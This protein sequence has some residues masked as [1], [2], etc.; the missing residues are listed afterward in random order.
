[1]TSTHTRNPA[2][3]Q[4]RP[5]DAAVHQRARHRGPE[6]AGAG[7][8]PAQPGYVSVS[9]CARRSTLP[10]ARRHPV[11]HRSG[12]GASAASLTSEPIEDDSSPRSFCRA[13]FDYHG[14]HAEAYAVIPAGPAAA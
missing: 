1:M 11:P 7:S 12:R 9:S 10:F 14:I 4:P 3:G 2:Q 8:R 5:A 13:V 6:P